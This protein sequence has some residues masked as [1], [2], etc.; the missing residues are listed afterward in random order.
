MVDSPKVILFSTFYRPL[1]SGAERFA[2]EVVARLGSRYRFVVVTARIRRSLPAREVIGQGHIV[3]LGLGTP[4]DKW[5]YP[6]LA[7]GYAWYT[8]PALL[9]AVMESYAG[10]A[11]ALCTVFLPRVP[12]LLTLQSGDL[13]DEEK[14]KKIPQWLWCFVHRAPDHVTAISQFLAKRAIRLRGSVR[15][16][17]VIPNGVDRANMPEAHDSVPGRI[18]CVARLSKEKGH[19]HLL[20]AVAQVRSFVPQAH[21]VLVGDGPERAALMKEAERLGITSAVR[22]CG[23]QSNAAALAEVARAEVFACPSHAEGLGIAFIEAQ[24]VGVPVIGTRVGGIPEVIEDGVTGRLVSSHDVS[25]LARVIQELLTNRDLAKR[26]VSAAQ[27][28]LDRFDWQNIMQNLGERYLQLLNEKR[29][30]IATGIFPPAIGG[31]ATYVAAVAPK[32]VQEGW[33]VTVVTY[34]GP[35]TVRPAEFATVVVPDRIPT[36]LRH[37]WYAGV[38]WW[39]TRSVDVLFLQDPVSAGLPV[40]LANVFTRKKT[41]LKIVGDHAWEQA[42]QRAHVVDSLDDFQHRQYSLFV[43]MLRFGEH[44]VARRAHHVVTPSDYLKKI[45][46]TWGVPADRV[47]VVPNAVHIPSDVV[48]SH[49]NFLDRPLEIVTAGRFVPWKGI[50]ELLSVFLELSQKFPDV[51]LTCIGD[52][53][54]REVLEAD[55]RILNISDTVFFTGRLSQTETLLRIARSRVFVLNSGYE[56]FSHQLI[57]AMGVG[58]AIV[59]TSAGGNTEVAQHE[60]NALVVPFGDRSALLAAITRVLQ[61][62]TLSTHLSE[63]ARVT[64]AQYTPERMHTGLRNVLAQL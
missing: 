30:L 36:G 55:A 13:D 15:A 22:F 42:Q 61:D 1:Q 54:M 32:L 44:V 16:V 18:V 47:T 63:G 60:E 64:A 53:P 17:S 6:F 38:V 29:M 39:Y 25:E 45:V 19:V 8:R 50:R 46:M 7:A 3:R 12:R 14:Q 43:E 62:P 52:G 27:A 4:I 9:H 56:G 34:G 40:T 28:R 37:I 2:E 5:L 20:Q 10:I 57:E 58:A 35:Q 23:M 33:G 48:P 31:P 21:V 51:R 41:L 49:T 11:L 59:C 24:A 26:F